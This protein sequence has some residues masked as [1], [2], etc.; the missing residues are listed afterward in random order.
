MT[1]WTQ[2]RDS[3]EALITNAYTALRPNN[4]IYWPI[5]FVVVINKWSENSK[6]KRCFL[7][8]QPHS[9]NFITNK[10]L[11]ARW[12][13]AD[14]QW[15]TGKV[16]LHTSPSKTMCAGED[17]SDAAIEMRWVRC[18]SLLSWVVSINSNISSTWRMPELWAE[19]S[20]AINTGRNWML[21]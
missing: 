17:R 2:Q 15:D 4:R 3:Q 19:T 16:S 9:I 8:P 21:Y 5:N 13:S 7:F 18:W 6:E 12:T 20:P 14:S 10:M 11:F 1:L